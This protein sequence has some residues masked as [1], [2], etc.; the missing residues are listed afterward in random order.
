[1]DDYLAWYTSLLT[2][3]PSENTTGT[4]INH[5]LSLIYFVLELPPL[6]AYQDP[7]DPDHLTPQR[8][9][10]QWLVRYAQAVG[11][12]M[13]TPGSITPST[14]AS[15]RRSVLYRMQ[16][17]P[18][19][20]EG[21]PTFNAFFARHVDPRKRPI[22]GV[23]D[24]SVVVSPADGRYAGAWRISPGAVVAL[25][26]IE[27]TIAD[28]LSDAAAGY[29]GCFA[30]GL[31]T[32]VLLDAWNYHRVHAPVGGT[33][34]AVHQI[35]GHCHCEISVDQLES[36]GTFMRARP[37]DAGE[38]LEPEY[39][40]YQFTQAR[41]LVLIDSAV[42]L[43]GVLPV[44]MCQVASVVPT[45]RPGQKIEKGQE[46]AFFQFGGSDVVVLFEEGAQIDVAMEVGAT[47]DFG[48]EMGRARIIHRGTEL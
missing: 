22:A 24:P 41:A 46:L 11:A 48:G 33:V 47:C 27:W 30:G 45:V 44:G 37:L 1:M 20:I 16:D 26:G 34:R 17:Y 8:W 32:H 2:W 5:Q 4:S 10:L 38:A 35:P 7:I 23:L 25:K 15:F 31:F 40:G 39:A 12:W 28:L 29:A 43:V 14:L 3:T 36:Y 6:K 13:D 18:E 42:G 21:W 9:L 19:P